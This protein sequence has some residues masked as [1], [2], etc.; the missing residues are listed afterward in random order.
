MLFSWC[1][2]SHGFPDDSRDVLQ[3]PWVPTADAN[4]WGTGLG[5]CLASSQR[6]WIDIPEFQ[7]FLM[8]KGCFRGVVVRA[9]SG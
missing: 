1:C 4:T 5:F 7:V 2:G 9:G 6:W 3:A 8:E